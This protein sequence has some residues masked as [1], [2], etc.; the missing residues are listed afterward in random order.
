MFTVAVGHVDQTTMLPLARKIF[1]DNQ[2][3][4]VDEDGFKTNFCAQNPHKSLI[5]EKYK[6]PKD[7][8]KL[9]EVILAGAIEFL[10]QSGLYASEYKYEVINLWLNQMEGSGSQ[11]RHT[12][13]GYIVS[14]CFYVDIPENCND[15]V[16]SNPS[17]HIIPVISTKNFKPTIYSGVEYGISPEEG[18]MFFWYSTLDHAVPF[19]QY[20]GIR[21]CIPFDITVNGL[22][23]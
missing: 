2:D 19:K 18:S 11:V 23:D 10:E 22:K 17:R 1:A 14:G 15:I 4:L 12:H 5:N 16:F 21:R 9:K 3:T 8:E 6:Y 13:Y 7:V 20:S